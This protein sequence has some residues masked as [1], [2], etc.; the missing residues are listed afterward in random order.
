M[1]ESHPCMLC[2]GSLLCPLFIAALGMGGLPGG[3]MAGLALCGAALWGVFALAGLPGRTGDGAR[4]KTT[5]L[6]AF[7]P[8]LGAD[9]ACLFQNWEISVTGWMV[10]Y[11][12]MWA[13]SRV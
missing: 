1:H 9:R 7:A 8:F 10:T 5:G 2:H 13:S 4:V 11:F 6:S 12:R 3:P